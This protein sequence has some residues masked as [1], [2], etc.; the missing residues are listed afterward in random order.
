MFYLS[1]GTNTANV[2][3][4][5]MI[6]NCLLF[7]ALEI[8][9]YRWKISIISTT[10][11]MKNKFCVRNKLFNMASKALQNILVINCGS[12]SVKFQIVDPAKRLRSING[13][14]ERLGTPKASLK[15][16]EFEKTKQ[17]FQIGQ[18]DHKTAFDKIFETLGEKYEIKAIGHRVV[19][20]GDYFQTSALINNDV[21]SK[22]KE[23]FPLAPIH[24]P[25]NLMGIDLLQEKYP[26]LTQVAVFDTS[27]HVRSMP[28]KVFR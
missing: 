4:K 11:F 3:F 1:P 9:F 20:G 10:I 24:N 6:R 28:E 13:I 12:S 16:Q 23:L 25:N 5:R 17:T 8:L 22:I 26:E 15:F 19:H 18:A 21:R 27:F 2:I 14:I 7:Y